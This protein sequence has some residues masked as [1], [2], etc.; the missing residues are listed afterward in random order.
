MIVI[1][2]LSKFQPS[3]LSLQRYKNARSKARVLSSFQV[4]FGYFNTLTKHLMN[5]SF[6]VQHPE[7]VNYA[8]IILGKK[9][10][11]SDFT[12]RLLWREEKKLKSI[13][14]FLSGFADAS[15]I[16]REREERVRKIRELQEEERKK[17][18]EELK[19]HV[20]SSFS[21][22]YAEIVCSRIHILQTTYKESIQSQMRR[23]YG[24][25]H[26]KASCDMWMFLASVVARLG[27]WCWPLGLFKDRPWCSPLIFL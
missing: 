11:W 7:V 23:C 8:I 9:P 21:I 1:R 20:S 13:C 25:C 6:S 27:P 14:I 16:Q 18:I 2:I 3:V 5:A 22:F 26:V 15:A 19:Q 17:K 10:R 24:Q 4:V 12:S